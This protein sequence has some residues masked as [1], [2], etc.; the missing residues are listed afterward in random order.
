MTYE[1][2]RLLACVQRMPTATAARRRSVAGR[3]DRKTLRISRHADLLRSLQTATRKQKT[4]AIRTIQTKEQEKVNKNLRKYWVSWIDRGSFSYAGPWWVSGYAFD[5]ND[6]EVRTIVAAVMAES[7][8]DVHERIESVHDEK[9]P[10]EWRFVSEQEDDWNPLAL[11]DRF[12]AASWMKWPFEIPKNEHADP[13]KEIAALVELALSPPLMGMGGGSSTEE[14]AIERWKAKGVIEISRLCIAYGPPS[15]APE[16]HR[17]LDI[18]SE[19]F[20][21]RQDG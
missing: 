20:G 13:A 3:M 6:A 7:E 15:K 11:G 8:R 4:I 1:R 10:I 21:Y 12:R 18:A 16:L 19:I 5:K 9:G 17:F 2:E 14:R